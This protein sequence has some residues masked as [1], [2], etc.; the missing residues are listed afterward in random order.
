MECYRRY[1][2]G[3]DSGIEDIVREYG[4]RLFWY[5]HAHL[6][7]TA[8]AE[9]V[10]SETFLK[11]AVRRHPFRG[12]AQFKTWLFAIGRNEA[13]GYLRRQ[14]RHPDMPLED[15]TLAGTEPSPEQVILHTEQKRQLYTALLSL[16]KEYREVLYLV[17]FEQLT[18]AQAAAVLK[19]N[20]KQTENLL[21]RGKRALKSILEKEGFCYEEL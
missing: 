12:E 17:Y 11:L 1:L 3:D 7:D 14:A 20:R 5:L 10:L 15:A 21:Y 2:Q 4:D 6:Q 8:A 9:D 19:K 13:L 18:A 16:R